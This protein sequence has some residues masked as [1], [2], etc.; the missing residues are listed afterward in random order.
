MKAKPKV[1]EH[2]NPFDFGQILQNDPTTGLLT[3]Y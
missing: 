2:S 1:Y 3:V